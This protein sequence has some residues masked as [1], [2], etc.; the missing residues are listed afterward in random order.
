M[1][2]GPTLIRN[3]KL[4]INTGTVAVP[5][6]VEIK[7]ITE[8]THSPEAQRADKSTFDLAGYNASV[9]VGRGDSF[10][11]AALVYEDEANGARDPGQQAVE[12]SGL[13]IGQ[14]AQEQYRITR[15]G[16]GTITFLADAVV[17]ILGGGV[18]D[19]SRWNVA[20]TAQS[21]P[22]FV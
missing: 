13:E 21:K 7:G 16:G 17:T 5:T 18:N 3:V 10:T 15:A 2:A 11:G 19:L 20:L 4:S 14:A 22:T 12:T 9:V 6:W 8:L 1:A